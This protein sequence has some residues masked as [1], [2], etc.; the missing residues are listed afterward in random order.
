M[1]RIEKLFTTLET[2]F[3][4]VAGFLLLKI[5]FGFSEGMQAW[6]ELDRMLR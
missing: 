2:I 1:N 6:A 4:L 5:M 3:I